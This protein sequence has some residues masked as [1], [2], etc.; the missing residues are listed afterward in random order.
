LKDPDKDGKIMLKQ[1][2]EKWDG[3]HGRNRF[4]SRQE[5]TADFCEG[6]NELSGS[7]KCGEFPD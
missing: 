1:I 2:L 4:G 3:G 6:G 5:K 7:I